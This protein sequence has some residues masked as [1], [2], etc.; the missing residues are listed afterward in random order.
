MTAWGY[1]I[2]QHQNPSSS[3][4]PTAQSPRQF[5]FRAIGDIQIFSDN[6]EI[7]PKLSNT[8]SQLPPLKFWRGF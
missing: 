4:A 7:K 2:Q 6:N 8:S 5:M 1:Y 3:E